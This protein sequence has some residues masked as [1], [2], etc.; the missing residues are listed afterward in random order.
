MLPHPSRRHHSSLNLFTTPPP[1]TSPDLLLR[2]PGIESSHPGYQARSEA[3][4]F[5]L[6]GGVRAE[7]PVLEPLPSAFLL[8][9]L[10]PRKTPKI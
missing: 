3:E 5:T 10:S 9:T 2:D 8:F 1:S 4:E 7:A 6:K